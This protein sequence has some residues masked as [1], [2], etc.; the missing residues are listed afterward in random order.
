LKLQ[1]EHFKESKC[2]CSKILIVDDEP[3]NLIA[4][5]AFLVQLGH[6]N[7]DTADDGQEALK[8]II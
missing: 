6:M 7:V 5:K 3:F 4:L 2:G 8:M 1:E